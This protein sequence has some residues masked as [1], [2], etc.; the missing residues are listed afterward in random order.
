MLGR[1][2]MMLAGFI[3]AAIVSATPLRAN[4]IGCSPDDPSQ[5]HADL[6]ATTNTAVITDTDDPRLQDRLELFELQ[7]DATV[8]ANA[9]VPTGS[10]LVGGVSWSA[11]QSR[12]TYERSRD[13]HLSCTDDFE[14]H[15]IAD[16]VRQQ[17]GQ[18]SVLTF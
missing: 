18:G 12:M 6:F 3:T 9:A 2:Q 8:L 13:F 4:I 10:T 16:Q 11:E 14:L 7:V 17:S 1:V 5:P 15:R